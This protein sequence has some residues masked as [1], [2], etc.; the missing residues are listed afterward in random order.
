MA[1]LLD[2]EVE[3]SDFEKVAPL[4]DQNLTDQVDTSR[5]IGSV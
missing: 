3:I 1:H 5:M 2:V 4:L